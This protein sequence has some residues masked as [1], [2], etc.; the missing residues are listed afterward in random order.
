VE[1]SQEI[2]ACSISSPAV[3]ERP[4]I[5]VL[6][7]YYWPGR[8]AT[9]VLLTELCEHLA[10]DYDV[11][12]ITGLL[13]DPPTPA[14]STQRN[15]VRIVRVHSTAFDR[16]RLALRGMNYM[17]YLGMSGLV[18]ARARRPDLVV[19]MTD[20]PV[21]GVLGVVLAQRWRAPLVTVYQDVFPEVAVELGRLDNPALVRSLTVASRWVLGH[22]TRVVA[23]GETMKRRLIAKGARAESVIV[24]PNWANL[25]QIRP[26]PRRNEWSRAQALDDKFVVMHSGNIGYAQ[27]IDS[28]IRAATFL[29]DRKD[30]VFRIIGAGA[31]GT[32]LEALAKRLDADNITFLPYQP[33][34][35]LSSSL[36]AAD[37]A[38]GRPVL[39]AADSDSETAQ[40]AEQ[41]ACGIVVPPARP[42]RLA[43]AIRAAAEGEFD[44]EAMGRRGRA[45]IERSGSFESAA[46]SY[47][48]LFSDL[49]VRTGHAGEVAA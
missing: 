17:S 29:R 1:W 34:E 22:S 19:A 23:I 35:V 30:V 14:G 38:V 46:E 25:S 16:R 7:Q 20:P 8:E 31:R 4:H 49:I 15:G 28:L 41:E 13:H 33:R 12:V 43:A 2:G 39:V 32:E 6:N 5:L 48:R 10:H 40:I 36:S 27:D 26:T 24:I 44:L 18:S 42:D 37:L 11:T 3:S 45:Y 47:V 9:A 21:V